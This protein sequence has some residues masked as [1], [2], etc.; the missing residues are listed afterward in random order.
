[1]YAPLTISSSTNIDRWSMLR[2]SHAWTPKSLLLQSLS[3][4][5]DMTAQWAR[6]APSASLALA[7]S[8]NSETCGNHRFFSS[9]N[10]SFRAT[11]C[12]YQVRRGAER[13]HGIVLCFSC[14]LCGAGDHGCP[15]RRPL[16]L[17]DSCVCELSSQGGVKRAE[18]IPSNLIAFMRAK[19]VSPCPLWGRS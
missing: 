16:I 5:Q 1:M 10:L 9:S 6:S 3:A 2:L 15:P 4:P 14:I 18:S 13:A 7:L 17:S 19:G 11:I 12:G 8:R